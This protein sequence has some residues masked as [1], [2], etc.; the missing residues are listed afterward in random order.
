MTGLAQ[1]FGAVYSHV[2]IADDPQTLHA[3]RIAAGEAKAVIGGDLVVSASFDALAKM[4]AG[5]TKAVINEAEPPTADFLRD[6]DWRVPAA[7]MRRDLLEAVGED[8]ADF[9]DASALAVALLGDAIGGNLLL[10]G[11]AWQ[12]GLVPVSEAAIDRAIELNGVA[13]EMNRRAFLW[14]R[15]AACDLEAVRRAAAPGEVVELEREPD[16]DELVAERREFLDGYQD[17]AYATRYERLVRRARDAESP[18]GHDDLARAVARGYFKVLSY[19]D[20]YEVARLHTDPAFTARIEA[21]FEGEYR[22]V[23][24]LAPPLWARVDARTGRAEKR[25]YGPWMR[26]ALGWLAPLKRLRGT[27]LDPFGHSEERR[28][29]RRDIGEYEALVERLLAGL[30][31][32]NHA[33]ALALASLALEL[34]GFGPVKAANRTRIAARR[35]ELLA[36]FEG[37]GATSEAA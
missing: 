31:E 10:L 12:K 9:L 3:V 25:P 30:T 5:V 17:A 29:E 19:K 15:R 18:L 36:L 16:L 8:S 22:L 24:H 34:R 28:A 13:V 20:E 33:H 6:P 1:K 35:V 32:H 4:R 23:H 21:A 27:V 11:F 14:G 2:R 7:D 26:R 37:G